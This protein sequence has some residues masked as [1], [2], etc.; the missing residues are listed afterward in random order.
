[1]IKVWSQKGHEGYKWGQFPSPVV[2]E[3]IYCLFQSTERLNSGEINI[4]LL[5]GMWTEIAVSISFHSYM[6]YALECDTEDL[7]NLL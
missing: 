7:C 3:L 2:S 1:M 6:K 5:E 4:W